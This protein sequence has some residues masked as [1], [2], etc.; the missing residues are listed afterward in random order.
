MFGSVR[1]CPVSL[2][3][4]V[5]PL[6]VSARSL[7][8]PVFPQA[9]SGRFVS[10]ALNPIGAVRAFHHT[11]KWQQTATAQVAAEG[12]EELITRFS[13]MSEK[14]IVHQN[15]VKSLRQMNFDNM[16]EVQTMTINQAVQGN[17]MYVTT[18]LNTHGSN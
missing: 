1:R 5:L 18:I 8:I 10:S 3:R 11:P 15:V 17:D 9:T 13:Q 12:E 14:G 6:T 7:R 2:P 16:T 4:V